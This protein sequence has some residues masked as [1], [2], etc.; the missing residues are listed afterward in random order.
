MKK[1]LIVL[2]LFAATLLAQNNYTISFESNKLQ[3]FSNTAKDQTNYENVKLEGI[4]NDGEPGYPLLPV[5]YI[6]LIIPADKD[7]GNIKISGL[8]KTQH[9]IKNKIFPAQ[10]DIPTSIPKIQPAF[11]E[12]VK[13]IYESDKPY[14]AK[15]V[16]VVDHGYFDG[17]NHIVTL[18]VC[19]VQ[20]LPK[21]GI[22]LIEF[23]QNKN[24]ALCR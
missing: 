22:L 14:P 23:L 3:I 12:P 24:K 7:V 2:F 6:Q 1:I 19:P 21:S 13:E 9:T 4:N 15:M 16:K 11:V 17:A 8:G 20:Y 10:P 18:A 5:K